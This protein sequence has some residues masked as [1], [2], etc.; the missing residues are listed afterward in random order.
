[1][2]LSLAVYQFS[3]ITLS[4]YGLCSSA[5]AHR[6]QLG[7]KLLVNPQVDEE[8]GQAVDVDRVHEVAVYFTAHEDEVHGWRERDDEGE[9]QTESDLHR[10]R[11][12]LGTLRG[13]KKLNDVNNKNR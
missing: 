8:V 4:L 2:C 10:L 12:A 9:E 6:L 5:L 13:A 7:S 3:R 11:V 1:M